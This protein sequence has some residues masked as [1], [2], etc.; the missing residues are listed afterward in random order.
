MRAMVAVGRNT[1]VSGLSENDDWT[2]CDAHEMR[3]AVE[4]LRHKR[5]ER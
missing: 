5:G 3:G 1:G 2:T 4:Y